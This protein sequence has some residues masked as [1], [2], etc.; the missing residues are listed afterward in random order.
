[1]AS[2]KGFRL[3]TAVVGFWLILGLLAG[4]S[5]SPAGPVLSVQSPPGTKTTVI[6][7]R[8]AGRDM[9]I[10]M[11]DP[12]LTWVGRRRARELVEVLGDKG[13]TAI[14]CS[15]LQRN[16][17]TAQPLADYLGLKPNI[18]YTSRLSSPKKL[19]R[20]LLDEFL[21]KHTGGVVVWVGNRRNVE[22]MYKMVDGTGSPPTKYG[23]LVIVVIPDETPPRIRKLTYSK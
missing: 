9:Y 4:C 12:G 5:T 21:T 1:M 11:P 20:E 14:Y 7:L 18:V 23:T 16:R 3:L 17:Q 10:D 8:H 13:V 6:I 2:A 22:E 15:N 19:A